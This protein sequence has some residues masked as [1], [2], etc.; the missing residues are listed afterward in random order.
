MASEELRGF[1]ISLM[2]VFGVRALR[3]GFLQPRDS[4]TP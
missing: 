3:V 1:G 2:E 4:N